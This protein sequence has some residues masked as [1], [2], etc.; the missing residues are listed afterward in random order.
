MLP[1]TSHE[2]S[3][4]QAFALFWM[5]VK[6]PLSKKTTIRLAPS[7]PLFLCKPLHPRP[8]YHSLPF[9]LMGIWYFFSRLSL[10]HPLL[11]CILP[12]TQ[13][14]YVE[15][16][17]FVWPAFSSSTSDPAVAQRFL[18]DPSGAETPSTLFMIQ[19]L[20]GGLSRGRP[21]SHLSALSKE[22]VSRSPI[23]ANSHS[24]PVPDLPFQF[25]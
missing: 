3:K 2:C 19:P 8:L 10:S 5:P 15:G 4:G 11:R 20:P 22:R 24:L 13:T 17:C 6:Q 9:S 12:C 7:G 25:L 23:P 21:I 14:I 18:Q 1:E 16:K